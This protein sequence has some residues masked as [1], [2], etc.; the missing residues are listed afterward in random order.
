MHEYD[1]AVIL[2][3]EMQGD[4]I[5]DYAERLFELFQ[6]DAT[7]A[8]LCGVPPVDCNIE[9]PSLEEAVRRVLLALKQEGLPIQHVQIDPEN[10]LADAA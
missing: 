3:P 2:S 1:F 7:P 9:A 6:G 10:L 4:I 8:V 5:D